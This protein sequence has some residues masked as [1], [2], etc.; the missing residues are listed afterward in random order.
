MTGATVR[1]SGSV[2]CL[3]WA[4]KSVTTTIV[5]VSIISMLILS[6]IFPLHHR[7]L[8]DAF[9]FD[10]RFSPETFQYSTKITDN[11]RVS[12]GLTD[13]KSLMTPST[14]FASAE[15]LEK[16]AS[17]SQVRLALKTM[18]VIRNIKRKIPKVKPAAVVPL[19]F[20]LKKKHPKILIIKK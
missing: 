18:K 10:S 11:S 5:A 15:T 16:R 4:I 19:V 17:F 7:S 12:K 6:L 3:T 20:L 1:A 2:S 14:I 8:D 13:R 9:S